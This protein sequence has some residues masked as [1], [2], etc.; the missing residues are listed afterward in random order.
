VDKKDRQAWRD[1]LDEFGDL[2]DGVV[3]Q[4]FDH[5]DALER[6]VGA[7]AAIKR[8]YS[9][10][11]AARSG[12]PLMNH[13]DEGLIVLD[14]IGAEEI[15]KRAYCL[16]PLLQDDENLKAVFLAM[17][18]RIVAN[19]CLSNHAGAAPRPSAI[20]AVNK[21]LVADKVQN[22]KDFEQHHK[23]VH[24]ESERL[25]TYFSNWLAAL[26]VSEERYQELKAAIAS[27]Q[28]G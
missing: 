22:R 9:D 8:I 16:H 15:A 23:G 28:E 7:Y 24:P 10:K 17:E 26:G 12:L 3:D 21:M 14:A 4:L 6:Q 2:P 19:S 11:C 13:I 20:E 18:Y 5:I 25:S 27:A 1:H